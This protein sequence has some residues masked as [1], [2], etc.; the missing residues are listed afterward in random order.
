GHRRLELRV[1][2]SVGELRGQI[3]VE[4]FFHFEGAL[5]G[6]VPVVQ[7]GSTDI[8]EGLRRRSPPIDIIYHRSTR[9]RNHV[10]YE[11][12]RV[13]LQVTEGARR[14]PA[15][16]RKSHRSL[17]VVP[18]LQVFGYLYGSA[19]YTIWPPV[20]GAGCRASYQEG[21]S[22]LKGRSARVPPARNK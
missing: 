21:A 20:Q 16:V 3:H 8:T 5:N 19:G 13:L 12:I 17:T 15:T 22:A 6:H 7:A 10:P 4:V 9:G 2:E 14:I 11:S 18:V 1:V